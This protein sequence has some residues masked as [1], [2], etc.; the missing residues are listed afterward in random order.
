[1]S[2]AARI[3]L[4]DRFAPNLMCFGC[5]PANRQGL[6]IKSFVRGDVVEAEYMPAK[7]HIAFE[8]MINGGIIGVLLDC[9]MNWTAAWGLMT[10]QRLEVPPCT[11]TAE[12]KV[13]F[14]RPTPS[15]RLLK[16]SA[17]VSESSARKSVIEATL[18]AD[19]QVT[20]K[21]QGIFVAVRPG[22]PAYHRW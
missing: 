9:H 8:G 2:D 16:L 15:D 6:Q 21:G 20:A 19:Q 14:I 22:H 18:S 1:M 11:V 12:Y 17:R 7:H 10:A 4:Q 13:Q 5:G 3:S